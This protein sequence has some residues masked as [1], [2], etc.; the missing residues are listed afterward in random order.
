[1]PGSFDPTEPL[2][3]K[4]E[5]I[6]GEA[7]DKVREARA[8]ISDAARQTGEAID[9]HRSTLADGLDNTA[10][11]I[12]DSADDFAGGSRARDLAAGT[13]S[14]LGSAADYVRSHDANRMM[15]DVEHAIKTNPGPA[16]VV[17][18]AFGFLLGRALV[19]D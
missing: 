16:L 11:T 2:G 17:A 6:R 3:D 12:R 5:S 13:A 15:R 18:A 1:M 7:A 10:A 14:R 9:A 8:T 4:F 19:R